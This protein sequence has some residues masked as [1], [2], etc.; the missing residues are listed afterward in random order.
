MCVCNDNAS[1]LN[2]NDIAQTNDIVNYAL[3][4]KSEFAYRLLCKLKEDSAVFIV[5]SYIK[6]AIKWI[7]Q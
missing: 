2:D 1:Y 6:E 3:G 7:C 4:N 5:P